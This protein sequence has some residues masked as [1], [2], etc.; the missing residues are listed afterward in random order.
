[1]ND[2]WHISFCNRNL[3]VSIVLDVVEVSLKTLQ[4]SNLRETL[5]V[6]N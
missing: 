2:G 4:D 3:N 5:H 1:M 6:H